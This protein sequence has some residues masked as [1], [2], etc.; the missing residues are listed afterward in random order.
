MRFSD[1][2]G[3]PWLVLAGDPAATLANRLRRIGV[4]YVVLPAQTYRTGGVTK[5]DKLTRIAHTEEAG[6]GAVASSAHPSSSSLSS[7]SARLIRSVRLRDCIFYLSE[8]SP[9]VISP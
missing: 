3:R 7:D 6:E 1:E 2:E 9:S 5:V 4:D 8:G